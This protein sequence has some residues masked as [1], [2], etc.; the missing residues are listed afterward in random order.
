MSPSAEILIAA[1]ENFRPGLE[2][3]LYSLRV[4]NP[5][6][7]PV[8]VI[9][10]TIKEFQGL[11]IIPV[12]PDDYKECAPAGSR[13]EKAWFK[14]EAFRYPKPDI[15]I[16]LDADLLCLGDV[17]KLW[18]EAWGK[19]S[20]L[21]KWDIRAVPL[22]TGIS[23]GVMVLSRKVRD[24][25]MW[26]NLIK[27]G[28]DARSRDGGDQGA[29]DYFMQHSDNSNDIIGIPLNPRFNVLKREFKRPKWNAIKDNIG[30]LHYVGSRKPWD[31][32]LPM[33][34]LEKSGGEVG[35]ELL[36]ALWQRYSDRAPLE[37]CT[38]PGNAN[39]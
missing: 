29:I 15:V 32:G 5:D 25:S 12:N 39:L 3:L 24:G 21:P 20:S 17:S 14:L 1:E 30:F 31:A 19:F 27:I 10:H 2:T 8:S 38:V 28:R 13:F 11:D 6:H 23:S 35:Y 4:H 33:T 18:R 26:S 36:E 34:G 22:K 7:P 9:S 37:K 16:V